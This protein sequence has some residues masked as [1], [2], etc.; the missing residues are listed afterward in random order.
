MATITID[1][2]ELAGRLPSLSAWTQAGDEVVITRDGRPVYR[3]VPTCRAEDTPTPDAVI[4]PARRPVGER[5]G[6][7]V[8]IPDNF[9]DPASWA[10]TLV[11]PRPGP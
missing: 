8:W 10:D 1:V 6:G 9:N 3:L 5:G 7:G 2:S 4:P 11:D